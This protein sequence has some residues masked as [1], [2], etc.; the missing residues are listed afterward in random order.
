M[1]TVKEQIVARITAKG[2]GYTFSAKD[3]LDIGGRPLI[4][5]TLSNL[6]ADGLIRRI[7]RGLYDYPAV[8]E[9]LGGQLSP[10]MDQVAQ[11]IA[12]KF[13][14]TIL[15]EGALAA[16]QLGLSQ[17]VPAKLV[18]L[19]DGP[20]KKVQVGSGSIHFKHARPKE[21]RGGDYVSGLVVQALRHLG[22][23][24][25]DAKVVDR[26]RKRLSADEKAGLLKDTRYGTDWI[27]EVAQ[28]IAEVR[29]WTKQPA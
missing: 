14:W 9:A 11:A 26:L 24:N 17:Q 2:R 12:R 16:N 21:I 7:S 23:D 5:V 27:Y 13:R 4:D 28:R 6:L 29:T 19:S 22:K 25:V 10:D 3:L 8:S 1:P 15:P 20:T 18:Y